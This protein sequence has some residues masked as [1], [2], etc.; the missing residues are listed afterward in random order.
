ML[1][2]VIIALVIL[3]F[4]Y[5]KPIYAIVLI[6]NI[7]TIRALPELDLNNLNFRNINEGNLFL[8]VIIPLLAYIII[9]FKIDY[10]KKKVL[11]FFDYTDM[12]FISS[13]IIM[14]VYCFI[15]PNFL[16][17]IEYTVKYL[18][19]GLPY[20]YIIKIVLI[21]SNDIKKTYFDFFK[22]TIVASIVIGTLG[23]YLAYSVDFFEPSLGLNNK[24][25]IARITI[26][27]THPVP[28]SQTIGFGALILF[29]VIYTNGI[30]LSFYK[31]KQIIF[32]LFLLL[33]LV[34]LLLLANTRG[35]IISL[36][37]AIFFFII[38]FP[39]KISKK[40]ARILMIVLL[41]GSILAIN[42]IDLS[43]LFNRLLNSFNNDASFSERM[44][45]MKE[46]VHIIFTKPFGVGTYGFKYGYPHNIFLDYIVSFG[47]F[48][49]VLSFSLFI[50]IVYFF[51]LTFNQ[52][53][54]H[55]LLILLYC[56]IIYFFTETLFSFTLWMHK[57]LYLSIGLF[58]SF[59]YIMKK[60]KII[61]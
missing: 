26:P 43:S 15:A 18:L 4:S 7:N 59:I 22:A 28:Y 61:E 17:A 2:Y 35:V 23:L 31:R 6:L 19:I 33:Y 8:S 24:I 42:F 44:I 55:P 27:G 13:V 5:K 40:N 56:F 60:R 29:S 47:V 58:V 54:K 39:K 37:T 49:W 25:P 51:V 3:F 32:S 48:G 1:F 20:Y 52:R 53:K 50:M 57:G 16:E 41:I 12:F 21:N 34:F 30:T 45:L 38:L 36:F 46:A 9:V 14:S 10:T 11:Y